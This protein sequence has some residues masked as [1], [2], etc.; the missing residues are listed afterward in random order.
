MSL[1]LIFSC[2][3]E[4]FSGYIYAYYLRFLARIWCDFSILPIQPCTQN[5]HP[6]HCMFPNGYTYCIVALHLCYIYNI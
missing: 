4:H 1:L 6:L 5:V 3:F 2:I